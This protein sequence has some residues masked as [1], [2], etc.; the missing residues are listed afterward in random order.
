MVIHASINKTVFSSSLLVISFLSSIGIIWPDKANVF[1][2]HLQVIFVHHTGWF[3]IL[4]VA[5]F[6]IFLVFIMF[7]RF[8][9]IKL[10]PDHSAPE[11]STVSWISMLF[12][13]G[14]GIGLMFYGVSEPVMH[15]NDPP[16]GP[17]GTLETAQQAMKITFFHWGLHAWAAYA[18]IA[19]SLSYFSYRHNLPLLPRSILHPLI[20]NK[21]YGPIG[22]F[23]DTFSVIG[24]MFGIAT[25][26]GV[27]AMQINAGLNYLLGF[28]VNNTT[29]VIVI[30]FVSAIAGLSV[31]FGLEKGIKRLSNLNMVLSLSLMLLILC[32]GPTLAIFKAFVENTGSYFS[33]IIDMTFNLYMYEK[34][35]DWIGGWTLLY[36]S[37]WISW[38]PFVGVFIARISKG[39]TIREFLMGVLF[40]PSFFIFLW[41]CVFGNGA[42]YE[43]L[44]DGASDLSY[45]VEHNA[46]VALF[47]FLELFPF[48]SVLSAVSI[49][50]I[51]T[52]FVSS[53]DSGSLV[54]DTLTSDMH[55]ESAKWQ[56]V[57]W[58]FAEGV[59]AAALLV[60]GG[61]PALQ[62]MTIACALPL[63][64]M[65]LI[66]CYCLFIALRN[67]YLLQANIQD[68]PTVQYSK[69]HIS[70]KDRVSSLVNYPKIKESE[71]FMQD[72]VLPTLKEIAVEMCKQGLNAKVTQQESQKISLVVERNNVENFNYSIRLRKFSAPE[73]ATET[74]NDYYRAEVYLLQGGQQYDVMGYTKEQII[75]DILN[76]Y[77][78]HMQFI[79]LTNAEQIS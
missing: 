49:V 66:F 17:V 22:H 8:G 34:K 72:I 68:H 43:I 47:K 69:A 28:P 3:Y 19:L 57:F 32:I 45:A 51:V 15:F 44:Y 54:I 31:A 5:I 16:T 53:S 63:L 10:G 67:D 75:A 60:T 74:D 9:D 13:A 29:Q 30:A 23:V 59:L 4:G 1:F 46:P 38:S 26:L 73:Y 41:F 18:I 61:L 62:T 12:S 24:T 78:R 40:V 27:G 39:R 11:H 14:M 56:R 50:L 21:I 76:Q 71:K 20:G 55:K 64:V 2:G 7:S 58:A 37:W 6:L 65:M 42:I 79:H 36:W 52:F 33:D 77:E 35:E 25:S 70:W 48:S